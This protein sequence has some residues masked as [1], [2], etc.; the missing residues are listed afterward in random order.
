LTD[1]Y[2]LEH[3]F[4][5]QVALCQPTPYR[6]KAL[7]PIS[8]GWRSRETGDRPKN[9]STATKVRLTMNFKFSAAA[10]A[11]G[12]K[13]GK[14]RKSGAA[15]PVRLMR[16][17]HSQWAASSAFF[18]AVLASLAAAAAV[19]SNEWPVLLGGL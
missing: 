11:L 9:F 17:L 6:D 8:P 4:L 3:W 15:L 12:G 7:R 13:A 16:R 5:R 19:A 18:A 1:F 2:G 14:E 10:P